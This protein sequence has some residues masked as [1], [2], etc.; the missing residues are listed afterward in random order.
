VTP[1]KNRIRGVQGVAAYNIRFQSPT[2]WL[3]AVEPAFRYDV[4]DPN[5]DVDNDQSTLITAVLGIYMS[6]RAQFRVAYER[7]SFQGDVAPSISGMRSAL[8]VNF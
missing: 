8:T 1:A 7:Q 2:S 6:S 5:T 3:Y 4:A